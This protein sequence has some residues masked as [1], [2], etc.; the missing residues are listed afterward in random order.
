MTF[1]LILIRSA[2]QAT[3]T[4]LGSTPIEC[5][6]DASSALVDAQTMIATARSLS[7]PTLMP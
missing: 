5:Q 4:T 7:M 6:Y 1:Y 3:L 2:A